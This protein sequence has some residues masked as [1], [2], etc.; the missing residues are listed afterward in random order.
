MTQKKI[1]GYIIFMKEVLG[2]GSYGSVPYYQNR[3]TVASKI[4]LNYHAP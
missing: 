1:N 4:V 3:F 2:K